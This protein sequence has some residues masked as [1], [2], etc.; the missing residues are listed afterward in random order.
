MTTSTQVTLLVGEVSIRL[1]C[2][3]AG[4]DMETAHQGI[5]PSLL[6]D[7]REFE[8]VRARLARREEDVTETGDGLAT[9]REIGRKMSESFL[10]GLV[11]QTLLEIVEAAGAGGVEVHLGF[12]VAADASSDGFYLAELPWEALCLPGSVMP[13]AL[14]DNVAVF[15]EAESSSTSRVPSGGLRILVAIAATDTTIQLVL[16]Y[17]QEL[18]SVVTAVRGARAQDA[19]VEVVEFATTTAIREAVERFDPHV[20]H[21]SCHGSPGLIYLENEDG[22]ERPVDADTFASEALPDRLVPVIALAACHTN[23]ATDRASSHGLSFAGGLLSAGVG[24]VVATE[25]AITDRYATV[26]LS[27]SYREL[28]TTPAGSPVA[29][30]SRARQRA[31]GYFSTTTR[32]VDRVIARLDEWAVMSVHASSTVASSAIRHAPPSADAKAARMLDAAV[33]GSFVGRRTYLRELPALLA[34]GDAMPSTIVLHGI[35]GIGKSALASELTSRALDNAPDLLVVSLTGRL[36]VESIFASVASALRVRAIQTKSLD[37]VLPLLHSLQATEEPWRERLAALQDHAAEH[38]AILLSLDN[39]EDNLTPP[40]KVDSARSIQIM[41]SSLAG[42]LAA[43]IG[44]NTPA[45][46][47]SRYRFALPPEEAGRVRWEALEPFSLAET[48]KFIWSLPRLDACDEDQLQ[49]LW[50]RIGGHPRLL[51]HVDDLLRATDTDLPPL[52]ERLQRRVPEQIPPSVE[53]HRDG[54]EASFE[55]AVSRAISDAAVDV[56]L[57]A[58]LDCVS[59]AAV[60]VLVALA[61]HR[62]PVAPYAAAYQTSTQNEPED[63]ND[64]TAQLVTDLIDIGLLSSVGTN[65]GP[66]VFVHRWTS[67]ELQKLRKIDAHAIEFAHHRAAAYWSEKARLAEEGQDRVHD[68]LEAQFHFL[69]CADFVGAARVAD[70]ARAQLH[71]WGAWDTEQ[72][73]IED[74]LAALPQDYERRAAWHHNLGIVAQERGDYPAATVQYRHALGID[75]RRGDEVGVAI[76]HHQLGVVAHMRDNYRLAE[77]QYKLALKIFRRLEM[78]ADTSECLHNLGMIAQDRGQFDIARDLYLQSMKIDEEQSNRSGVA[79]STRQLGILAQSEGNTDAA[80]ALFHKALE[81]DEAEGDEGGIGADHLQLGNLAYLLGNDGPSTDHY[82]QAL[83]IFEEIG[84]QDGIGLCWHQLGRLALR[85]SDREYAAKLFESALRLF[86]RIDELSNVAEVHLSLIELAIADTNPQGAHTSLGEARRIFTD[87]GRAPGLADLHH[88]SALVFAFEGRAGD[89]I[90]AFAEEYAIR[91]EHGL[92]ALPECIADLEEQ[93]RLLDPGDP[94]RA[95]RTVLRGPQSSLAELV[96]AELSKRD[97][98]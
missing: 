7:L 15:R 18:R 19:E 64:V 87:L 98:E 81:L 67:A 2:P 14:R 23:T 94:A 27:E 96:I 60:D 8:R 33:P 45:I 68:L 35:G 62:E 86:I 47:T 31:Q 10:P 22:T 57:P 66:Q 4:V 70:Q 25:T 49:S 39:F 52:Q 3:E 11:G 97:L 44:P 65:D 40:D 6:F 21:V 50:T 71:V 92:A 51:E 17:E 75:T 88:H 59:E 73:L 63:Y 36:L 32:P 29:A 76:A 61:V 84:D 74:M 89:A 13:L 78:H 24:M 69:A 41:D 46:I 56:V 54:P 28:A 91:A 9:L 95:I 90:R 82:Q 37:G 55:T 42:V 16:D 34:G 12:Q 48:L 83:T 1:V 38:G 53:P 26:M 93:A 30:A 79:T 58:L 43:W 77:T 20:L 85:T 72:F 5:R 80:D